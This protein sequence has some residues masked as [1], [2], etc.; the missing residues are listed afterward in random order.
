MRNGQQLQRFFVDPRLINGSTITFSDPISHQIRQVLRMNLGRDQVVVL[1]GSGAA[2][3]AR[4]NG[5]SGRMVT[6]D[7]VEKLESRNE[8]SV[9]LTLCFSLTR[10]E[11]VEWILQKCTEIGV[12]QFLPYVSE[13]SV[14][15]LDSL[16]ENRKTRWQS[17]IREA[18]E[19]SERSRLPDLL[20]VL[21]FEEVLHKM[22]G[23]EQKLIAYEAADTSK[24]LRQ[25]PLIQAP[26]VLL[27]GPEGGFSENEIENATN[28][29]FQPF[30]LGKRIFRMETACIV[31][32]ALVLDQTEAIEAGCD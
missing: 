3:L 13:R 27:I 22:G 26:V 21:T 7:I 25:L 9:D 32:S 2:F 23:L 1:D 15:R 19:Q 18:A 20:E 10:R 31:A 6:A 8:G 12:N 11:K 28:T 17:I 4:L 16:E 5:A 30:S 29:G 14:S 24:T